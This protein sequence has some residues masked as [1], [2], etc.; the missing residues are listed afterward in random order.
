MLTARIRTGIPIIALALC[1]ALAMTG[2]S[3]MMVGRPATPPAPSELD[4]TMVPNTPLDVYL[5]A[6]Q[7]K[8]TLFPADRLGIKKD[9]NVVSVAV[10][11]AETGDDFAIG[12]AAALSDE[13]DASR[14]YDEIKLTSE[15]WK[16]LSGRTIYMVQ[17]NNGAGQALKTAINNNDFKKY[18]D[19]ECLNIAGTLPGGD[20]PR[21]L[22]IA[23]AKPGKAL[24]N[25]VNREKT[26][27]P[28]SLDL[29]LKVVD[30]KAV[31]VGLYSPHPLDV[32]T[33]VKA[34]EKR[35]IRA[36]DLGVV[37][38]AR[39]GRP[40]VLVGPTVKKYLTENGFQEKSLGE[41]HLLEGEL[42]AGNGQKLT[43][44]VRTDNDY[45]FAATA[46]KDAYAEDLIKSIRLK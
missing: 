46:G 24:L 41:L 45:V 19:T 9:V 10:W 33:L 11:G 4:T 20:G 30:L 7:E 38:A 34:A 14:L 8:P 18:D 32:A 40:G 26:V 5:Y 39:S 2:A 31:G 28:T 27:D 16:K 29:M 15:G 36:I 37:L 17:G 35:D 1:L 3:C 43:V 21:P 12:I 22:A 6:R 23:L 25:Y 44:F 13:N 42:D